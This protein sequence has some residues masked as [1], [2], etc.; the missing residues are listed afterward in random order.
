MTSSLDVLAEFLGSYFYAGS[1]QEYDNFDDA[2]D[3]FVDGNA[4]NDWP[5]RVLAAIEE[6]LAAAVEDPLAETP[7][8]GVIGTLWGRTSVRRFLS[9]IQSSVAK[10]TSP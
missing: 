10:R 1:G 4:E 5:G 7:A 2:I 3:D 8:A 9:D 6:V